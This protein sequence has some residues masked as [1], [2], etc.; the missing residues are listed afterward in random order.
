MTDIN[1]AKRL[2]A[3]S[4]AEGMRLLGA[5][6]YRTCHQSRYN[7][8]ATAA[9]ND[10]AAELSPE[11]RRLIASYIEG[12]DPESRMGYTLRVRLSEF[13]RARLGALAE[14]AGDSMSEYVRWKLLH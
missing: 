14:R 12:E 6:V 11:E 7:A 3:A 2:I 10:P 5:G 9:L 1:E 13:E 4:S 8:A